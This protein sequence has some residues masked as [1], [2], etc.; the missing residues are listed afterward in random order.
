MAPM[1][2]RCGVINWTSNNLKFEAFSF[3]SRKIKTIFDA[4]FTAENIDSAKSIEKPQEN[5]RFGLPQPLPNRPK[6]VQD[7]PKMSQRP[8]QDAP[9]AAQDRPRTTQDRPKTGQERLKTAQERPKT[10]QE[11]SK[12]KQDR[13]KT[14]QERFYLISSSENGS[15]RL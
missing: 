14:A 13:P 6:T 2:A 3:A 9:R 7:R 15:K 10:T 11:R 1:D 4:F 8:P 12:I 5:P